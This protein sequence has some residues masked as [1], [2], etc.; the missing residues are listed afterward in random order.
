[1]LVFLTAC[2]KTEQATAT[3][4]PAIAEVIPE[5]KPIPNLTVDELIAMQANRKPDRIFSREEKANAKS[6]AMGML[7]AIK[8]AS[9]LIDSSNDMQNYDKFSVEFFIPL[10]TRIKAWPDII[11]DRHA[12]FGDLNSCVEAAEYLL[13]W[14]EGINRNEDER[15]MRGA[16]DYY[17]TAR[18]EC[19][20]A[21]RAYK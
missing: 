11:D 1:M 9:A 8:K 13:L 7:G 3:A 15:L 19:E 5:A 21:I 14:G 2:G 17:L 16:R 4:A 6:E 10:K 20:Q 18:P 12:P